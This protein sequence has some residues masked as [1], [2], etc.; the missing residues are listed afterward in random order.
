MFEFVCGALA[1]VA[2]IMVGARIAEAV[3]PGIETNEFVIDKSAAMKTELDGNM[4]ANLVTA[5]T[6]D[7]PNVLPADFTEATFPGYTPVAAIATWTASLND[8]GDRILTSPILAWTATTI[9][10]PET[11]VGVIISLDPAIAEV[12]GTMQLVDI[13]PVSDGETLKGV[14]I[15]NAT[16]DT[17]TF[18][19]ISS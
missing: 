15:W 14:V 11:I 6:F 19:R 12:W 4:S 17:F 3:N 18:Q 10:T 9:I 16:K 13:W 5:G 2:L 7:D 1:L 8:D